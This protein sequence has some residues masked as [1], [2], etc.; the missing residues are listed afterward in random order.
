MWLPIPRARSVAICSSL[1]ADFC[2][3]SANVFG[4][5]LIKKK[6]SNHTTMMSVQKFSCERDDMQYK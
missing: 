1:E 3:A 4:S 5:G 2:E 6:G